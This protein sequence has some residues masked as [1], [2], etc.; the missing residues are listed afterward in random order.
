MNLVFCF[1][2]LIFSVYICL[3]IELPCFLKRFLNCQIS[4]QHTSRRDLSWKVGQ[5]TWLIA[6]VMS[7]LIL[8]VTDRCY[9][10]DPESARADVH[11][12]SKS[13]SDAHLE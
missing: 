3:F 7:K 5:Q 8:Q 9:V 13:S 4:K 6:I 2:V 12:V 10:L 11:L 1:F